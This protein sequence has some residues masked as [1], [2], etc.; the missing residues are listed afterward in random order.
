MANK[1]IVSS[2]GDNEIMSVINRRNF[3]FYNALTNIYAGK[4]PWSQI[5]RQ[6]HQEM[7]IS[8]QSGAKVELP[9]S[10]AMQN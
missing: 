6:Y 2:K 5:F 3:N 1:W 9:A 10:I 8:W 7:S 4:E